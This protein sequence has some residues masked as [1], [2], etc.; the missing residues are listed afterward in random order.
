MVTMQ[1]PADFRDFLRLLNDHE[2][3]YLL[4]G[5]YAVAYHGYPR[6]TL[7]MDVWVSNDAA[8]ADRMVRVMKDFGFT[9]SI[10]PEIFRMTDR[11]VRMGVPP[12]KLEIIMEA[13]GVDFGECFAN[14]VTDTIDDI[15]VNIISL[16]DLRRNKKASGR[17]KDLDDLEHLPE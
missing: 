12:M 7:D 15:A 14:R 1:L 13:S 3:E 16:Q 10:S 6:T 11:V 8:N 9:G 5:G 17:H 4:V 2:V